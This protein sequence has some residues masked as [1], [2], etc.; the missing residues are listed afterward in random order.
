M[1]HF[2]FEI[3]ILQF[4]AYFELKCS[5]KFHSKDKF[6]IKMTC[7]ISFENQNYTIYWSF[8]AE[9]QSDILFQIYLL[10]KYD[11]YH[12]NLKSKF[13]NFVLILS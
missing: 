2:L 10:E 11:M 6:L 8:L 7:I 5:L 4:C 12:F 3:K 9:I 1:Y 13:Y